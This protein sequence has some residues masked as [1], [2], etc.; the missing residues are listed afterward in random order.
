M[1]AAGVSARLREL[2]FARKGLV[3]RRTVED[4]THVLAFQVERGGGVESR[5]SFAVGTYLPEVERILRQRKVASPSVPA[6]TVEGHLGGWTVTAGNE[7]DVAKVVLKAIDARV[8]PWFAE[9]TELTTL[10]AAFDTAKRRD[11]WAPN[12][13]A[14]A[15]VA[16]ANGKKK[17]AKTR[18]ADAVA[19]IETT[20]AER[21]ATF[22]ARDPFGKDVLALAERLRKDH[23]L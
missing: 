20:L 17:L 9:T 19:R 22:G 14:A 8:L 1:I 13:L 12:M 7:A 10:S 2:G 6:C 18:V 21:F 23:A 15:A 3:F 4:V 5:F 11:L 16:L